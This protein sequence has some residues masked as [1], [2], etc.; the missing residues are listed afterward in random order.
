[1]KKVTIVFFAFFFLSLKT[2]T[3]YCQNNELTKESSYKWFDKVIG[4][5]NTGLYNGIQ[6]ER[7]FNPLHNDHEYYLSS[8]FLIGDIIYNGQPYYDILLKY[9][10]YNDDLIVKLPSYTS[11]NIIKLIKQHVKSFSINNNNKFV[12]IKASNSSVENVV[13]FYEVIFDDGNI[14]MYK[15]H[16]KSL[17]K[18]LEKS[19]V[20]DAFKNKEE[21]FLFYNNTYYKIKSKRN[22]FK[23]LPNLKKNINSYYNSYYKL[24]R[25]D[26][27]VFL[28]NFSK[29]LS[30]ILTS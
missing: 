23:I 10:I 7:K 11:F 14:K 6:Y 27:D 2:T 8:E 16:Q 4:V 17:K 21:Y 9:D 30:E 1:M 13:G 18:H 3:F 5:G 25:E 24:K 22:F 28:L 20:Y 19:Y 12:N 15:K 26:Y 29:Y